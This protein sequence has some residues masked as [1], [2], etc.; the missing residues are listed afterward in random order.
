MT[1]KKIHDGDLNRDP[2][3]GEPGAHPVGTGIGSASGAAA[4]A[5]VGAAVGGPIGAVVGGAVGAISGGL[6]GKGAAEAV[7]PTAIDPVAEE[8]FWRESYT[9]APG[10]RSDY[11][12]D[13]YGPAYHLG[14]DAYSRHNGRSYDEVETELAREWEMQKRSS[15]LNWDE[16][17]A[18]A[19]AAWNRLEQRQGSAEGRPVQAQAVAVP[20][21]DANPDPIT[22]EPGAHPVGTGVGAAGGAAAGAAIGTMVAGPVGTLVGGVIGAVSGGLAG[23]GAAEAVNPTVV[24]PTAE[25]AYWRG[26]FTNAP[27]YSAD[28][29]YDDY[30]PAYQLGYDSYGRYHGRSYDEVEAELA[31][32]WQNVK[33]NSRLSWEQAKHFTRGLAATGEQGLKAS[34][35][36]GLGKALPSAKPHTSANKPRGAS[37]CWPLFFVG[38]CITVQCRRSARPQSIAPVAWRF[39][40]YLVGIE[41]TKYPAL[42]HYEPPRPH[43]CR[44]RRRW[45]CQPCAALHRCLVAA[46]FGPQRRNE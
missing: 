37:T 40:R 31:R 25:D 6:A 30:G 12:F 32:E 1:D 11:T 28:Y 39:Y 34:Q 26:N 8:A 13:D 38:P 23:K 15:R 2:I 22:G 41:S 44:T 45:L 17:K 27:G 18:S 3:T 33:Q 16:A 42:C 7:N 29:S 21:G 5:A 24:D 43:P 36:I 19:R 10:Y 20:Q 9:K 14:Y 35:T 4:G 46:G